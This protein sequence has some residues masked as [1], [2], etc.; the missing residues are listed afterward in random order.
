VKKLVE[1]GIAMC[2]A[3]EETWKLAEDP[4]V[5]IQKKTIHKPGDDNRVNQSGLIVKKAVQDQRIP[6]AQSAKKSRYRRVSEDI[7]ASPYSAQT[8]PPAKAQ[9]KDENDNREVKRE[10]V[11][12]CRDLRFENKGEDNHDNAIEYSYPV[13]CI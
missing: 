3:E 8:A 12:I 13:G 6:Q 11:V 7:A 10:M 5:Q 2:T 9:Q 1:E 4:Y